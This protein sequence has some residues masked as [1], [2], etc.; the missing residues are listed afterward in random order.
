MT[1]P[2]VAMVMAAAWIASIPAADAQT[3]SPQTQPQTQSPSPGAAAIPDRKLDAT[4]AAIKRVS[5]IKQSYEQQIAAASPADKQRLV[6]EGNAALEKAVTDQG[7]SVEEYD[8]II[9]VAQND[10]DVHARLMQRL[11]TPAR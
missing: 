5:S 10:P 7:L 9:K 11:N 3:R 4:A 1:R 2:F 6:D 8:S